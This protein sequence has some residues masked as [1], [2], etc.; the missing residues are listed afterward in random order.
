MPH[1]LAANACREELEDLPHGWFHHGPTVLSL[2]DQSRPKVYV[3]LGTWFGASAIAVAR[4]VRRWGG[5]VTCIDT[6]AGELNDDGG[7]VGGKSPL[8]LMSCAR[9][10]VEAGVSASVRLVPAM[11]SEAAKYWTEPIDF[12]YIDADH[13]YEG[14]LADLQA[15]VPHVKKGGV[16]AGDDYNHPRYPGVKR[17]W[18][19]Y[20]RMTGLLFALSE[21]EQHGIRLIYGTV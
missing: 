19:D 9:A 2:V 5:T 16:V 14:V 7:S 6:W 17:A 20:E 4:S 12:L 1:V 15:W 18:H 3:E 13:S 21:P 8:M 10:M 11:T